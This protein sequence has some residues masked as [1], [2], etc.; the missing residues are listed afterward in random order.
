MT[1]KPLFV[2]PCS[3]QK[4]EG[5]WPAYDLYR[6]KGYLPIIKNSNSKVGQDFNL[7]FV[8]AK[9]GFVPAQRTIQSYDCKLKA[10]NAEQFAELTQSNAL[11]DIANFSPSIIYCCL[12]SSY[13]RVF[14][15]WVSMSQYR[16][17]IPLI[18]GGIGFQRQFL[19]KSLNHLS[20]K[21]PLV[22]HAFIKEMAATRSIQINVREGDQVSVW[23]SG[24]PIAGGTFSAM[25][26]VRTVEVDRFGR[27][28]GITDDCGFYWNHGQVSMGIK[29]TL[30]MQGELTCLR[31]KTL[32]SVV[33][34]TDLNT[35]KS[36]R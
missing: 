35:L 11:K 16:C 27:P 15:Q 31:N 34:L 4:K 32:I 25:R 36:V 5:S 9:Y 28:I 29:N 8:S 12:P 14:M 1:A 19:S 33:E 17:A 26:T 24:N 21:Q 18:N 30:K 23:I 2:I 10:A 7:A 3:A 13:E 6:G 22:V 20:A